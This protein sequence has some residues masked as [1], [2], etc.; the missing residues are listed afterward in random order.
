LKYDH[1]LEAEL[2]KWIGEVLGNPLG[3]DFHETLKSGVVLCR[4]LNKLSP[5][6]VTGIDKKTKMP[7][8]QRENINKFLKGCRKL[9]VAEHSMFTT[10]DLFEGANKGAVLLTLDTLRRGVLGR[11][12]PIRK[13]KMLGHRDPS[14]RKH[15]PEKQLDSVTT[16]NP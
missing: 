16:I 2:R 10:A 1:D 15:E 3:D 5:K 11:T 4:L 13:N 8:K 6:T 14:I 7:F 12:E 9:G